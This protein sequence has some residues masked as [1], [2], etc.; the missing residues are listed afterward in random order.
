MRNKE[1]GMEEQTILKGKEKTE[2]LEISGCPKDDGY[3]MPAEFEKHDGCILVWPERPGSWPHNAEAG[4]RAFAEVIKAIARSEHVYLAASKNA[5]AQARG[6]LQNVS[7]VEIFA[8]ETDDSW[9]RDIGPTFVINKKG[10]R[11]CVN[12]EF[13]AW[14]GTYNGLYSSWEKDN[15]FAKNFA[16]WYRTCYYDATPFVLEGGSIHCDGEGTVLVTEACLLSKGRNP[17]LDKNEIEQQLCRYLGVSKV[18]W[19][20][21]G[22]Y[23]D[24][25]DEHI[26][27]VCAFIRPGE[28]VLAWTDDENDPQ[29]AYSKASLEALE[30]AV[31]AKGRKLI[32]HKLPIPSVPVCITKEDLEGYVFEEGEDEREVGERLAASYVNFY[33]SNQS[34]VMP[35]F[36]GENEDSDRKAAFIMRELCPERE[37]IMV[38]ARDI[39]VGGG[40]I[41]CI[42]QQIPSVE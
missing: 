6:M 42:T 23:G 1:N 34:V 26:D 9:A 21:H 32:V 15:A 18:I 19:I 36:G 22:I 38:P 2:N 16:K 3:Y 17:E 4:R 31:D 30:A 41:H 25:T 39:L 8:A 28:V 29:Y 13:N 12:W 7:N 40:N 10:G 24:E 11:R 14:G 37:I 5:I 20:P 27:N 35:A 33:F